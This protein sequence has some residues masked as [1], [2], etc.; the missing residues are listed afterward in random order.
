MD[1][2]EPLK[3]FI[4][5]CFG[6]KAIYFFFL[7]LKIIVFSASEI[8]SLISLILKLV[9]NFSRYTLLILLSLISL[10]FLVEKVEFLAVI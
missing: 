8:L 1:Y 10:L 7:E 2:F 5:G 9:L 3:F 6:V 4:I